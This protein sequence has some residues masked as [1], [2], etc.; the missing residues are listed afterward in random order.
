MIEIYYLHNISLRKTAQD[1]CLLVI[2]S[3]YSSQ[4]SDIRPQLKCH[5]FSEVLKSMTE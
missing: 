5:L 4:I 2:G 3:G 1:L